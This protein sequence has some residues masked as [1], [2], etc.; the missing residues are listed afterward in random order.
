YVQSPLLGELQADLLAAS[1]ELKLAESE[2]RRHDELKA[3]SLISDSDY[4]RQTAQTERAR[5]EIERLRGLLLSGGMNRG[6]IDECLKHATITDR[7]PLRSPATG[8]IVDRSAKLGELLPSGRAFLTLADPS[9][10]W[11]EAQLAEQQLRNVR[12]DDE[13]VFS[14]DGGGL[15]RVGARVIWIS[16]TLDPHTR[17]GTVRAEVND[18]SIA[19]QSGLFGRATI[20]TQT[21]DPV[22]LVPRDAVQWEG[23][24]N[25]VFVK[26][27]D[28][29]FRP[30]KVTIGAAEHDYYQITSGLEP[31]ESVVTAGAFLLKTELK[32]SSIGAGCC[33][34]EPAG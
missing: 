5:A 25:I 27:T 29:R 34:I 1:A 4:E 11:I 17:T 15:G 23:C 22:T 12:T 18:P 16:Q 24:C 21:G 20:Y 6:D 8:L 7:F 9:H 2:Q 30:R 3:R 10:L 31:G 19:L 28:H 26:E 13:L 33:G 14:A 32:K